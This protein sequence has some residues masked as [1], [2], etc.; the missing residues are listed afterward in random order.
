MWPGTL[1]VDEEELAALDLDVTR[2]NV[3]AVAR[4]DT[5]VVDP[6]APVD[7]RLGLERV[8]STV[9]GVQTSTFR[10]GDLVK[11]T[12]TYTFPDPEKVAE[13]AESE[14]RAAVV[15]ELGEALIASDD[16]AV[17]PVTINENFEI[18]D[19]LPSGLALV[20]PTEGARWLYE[21]K[22]ECQDYPVLSFAQRV[23]FVVSN[24]W[25]PYDECGPRTITYYARVVTPGTY[26]AEP[27]YIRSDRDPEAN[28]HLAESQTLQIVE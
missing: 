16:E 27:A 10:E 2:G 28:N 4:Y 8:Y 15:S 24:F 14:S 3:M 17:E 21:S 19:V 13:R 11:I 7:V 5:P 18:T 20:S 26:E 12:I 25:D 22:I 1:I 23:T 6:D 9:D